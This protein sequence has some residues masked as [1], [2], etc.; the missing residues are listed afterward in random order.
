MID[1]NSGVGTQFTV[2]D[3]NGDGAPDIVIGNKK[4]NF[5]FLNRRTAA[6]KEAW[7]ALLPIKRKTNSD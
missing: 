4:G 7:E 1:D 6:S 2:E 5:I 3:L